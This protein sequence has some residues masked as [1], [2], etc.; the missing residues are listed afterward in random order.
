MSFVLQYA[1]VERCE[2]RCCMLR[3]T[4]AK[5]AGSVHTVGARLRLG[6]EWLPGWQSL[7]PGDYRE[8]ARCIAGTARRRVCS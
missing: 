7:H 8:T 1:K 5:V 3:V 4:I 2:S 6:L